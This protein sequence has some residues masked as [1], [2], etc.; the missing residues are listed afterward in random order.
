[1]SKK[2]LASA[3]VAGSLIILAP[4]IASAQEQTC[5]QV[6]GGG[7]VCGA[8][9]PEHKPLPTGI[10]ENLAIIGGGFVLAS[11]LLL[12]LSKKAKKSLT[13]Q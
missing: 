12:F 9:V 3:I 11:G 7:V 5:T 1:M 8:A 13:I 2:F 10:G 4:A 6:Y